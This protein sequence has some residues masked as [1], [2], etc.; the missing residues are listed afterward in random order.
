VS[1][2]VDALGE[3]RL[4]RPVAVEHL[5]LLSHSTDGLAELVVRRAQVPDADLAG[6]PSE[7]LDVKLERAPCALGRLEVRLDL[8][9][10]VERPVGAR[11][12]GL[13]GRAGDAAG[14][15]SGGVNDGRVPPV[16]HETLREGESGRQRRA[17]HSRSDALSKREE[18]RTEGTSP[19]S[20]RKAN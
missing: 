6:G 3:R 9:E 14:W 7:H 10:R 18:P 4:A 17:T 16:A 2:R 5:L 19:T 20:S 13:E 15:R 12:G 11:R 1:E 8:A